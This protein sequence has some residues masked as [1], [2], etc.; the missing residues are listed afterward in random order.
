LRFLS[1]ATPTLQLKAATTISSRSIDFT[2][3]IRIGHS[4]NRAHHTPDRGSTTGVG[5][6]TKDLQVAIS[7][8]SEAHNGQ[9]ALRWR[10][11]RTTLHHERQSSCLQRIRRPATSELKHFR[12]TSLTSKGVPRLMRCAQVLPAFSAETVVL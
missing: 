9:P 1:P 2:T 6:P 12:A 5:V 10:Q 11:T 3:T 8:G 7:E 4:S